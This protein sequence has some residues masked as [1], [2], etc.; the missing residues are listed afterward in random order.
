VQCQAAIESSE[1]LN[2]YSGNVILDGKGEGRI[3]FLVW[4]AAINEDFRYRRTAI[5]APGPN[6]YI[7]EEITENTFTVAGA[8]RE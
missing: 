4:F 1:V 7:A 6:V 8:S 2:Q 5:G 3:E